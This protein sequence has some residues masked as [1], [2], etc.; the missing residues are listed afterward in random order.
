MGRTTVADLMSTDVVTLAEDDD[1]VF[2]TG[3]MRYRRIRH[4]PS[5]RAMPRRRSHP[6]FDL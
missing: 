4:L 3:A 5:G 6:G 1:V 2:A